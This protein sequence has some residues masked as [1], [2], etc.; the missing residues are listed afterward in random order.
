MAE[1]KARSKEN[2]INTMY[3]FVERT[4]QNEEANPQ[5]LAIVPS[6]LEVLGNIQDNG[7]KMKHGSMEKTE[8]GKDW[9]E[10]RGKAIIDTLADEGVTYGEA[11]AIIKAAEWELGRRRYEDKVKKD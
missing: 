8:K 3:D 2:L 6:V 1:G 11:Q 4:L 5:A 10:K 7:G 9:K